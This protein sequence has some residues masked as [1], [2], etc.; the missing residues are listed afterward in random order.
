MGKNGKMPTPIT[1]A[2][3]D[4]LNCFKQGHEVSGKYIR[5][6]RALEQKG[7]ITNVRCEGKFD[8]ARG[9]C[10]EF[11]RAEI[12]D[13][14]KLPEPMTFE[15]RVTNDS[16][17]AIFDGEVYYEFKT[18]APSVP[19]LLLQTRIVTYHPK[20]NPSFH[21]VYYVDGHTIHAVRRESD[22]PS[23]KRMMHNWLLNKHLAED[24]KRKKAPI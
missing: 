8:P 21:G 12:I 11:Y 16:V 1:K 4:T 13:L 19:L 17:Q 3:Q 9:Y 22:V 7:L 23:G 5:S 15:S 18:T 10:H 14:N 24:K 20:R 2:Q 6:I